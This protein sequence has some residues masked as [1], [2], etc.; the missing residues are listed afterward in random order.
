MYAGDSALPF[1]P[2]NRRQEIGPLLNGISERI[3]IP[4]GFPFGLKTHTIAYVSSYNFAC[5][6]NMYIYYRLKLTE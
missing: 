3:Y 1:L 4:S 5:L 2:L 6:Y